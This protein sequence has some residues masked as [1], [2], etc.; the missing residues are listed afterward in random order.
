[1][2]VTMAGKMRLKPIV[3]PAVGEKRNYNFQDPANYSLW[4]FTTIEQLPAEKRYRARVAIVGGT[5]DS[6]IHIVFN[7]YHKDF[8]DAERAINFVREKMPSGELYNI[9]AETI[10]VHTSDV[11]GGSIVTVAEVLALVYSMQS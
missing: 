3:L 6:G 1:M 5:H 9:F 10:D 8:S 11:G 7:S 2:E 4:P